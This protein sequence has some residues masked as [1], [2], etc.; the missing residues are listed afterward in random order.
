MN[1]KILD[2]LKTYISKPSIGNK[3]FKVNLHVHARGNDPVEIVENAR[4]SE[5]DIIAITD[6]QTFEYYESIERTAKTEGREL[7]V[8]PGIE[9]TSI[10]GAHL[11]SLFPRNY[12]TTKRA[13]LIGWLGIRDPGNTRAASNKTVTKILNKVNE[14]GGIC[15]IPHPFADNIGL[16]DSARKIETRIEWLESGHVGLIQVNMEKIIYVDK[17]EDGNWINRYLLSSANAEQIKNSNYCL[18]PINRSDAQ[19]PA[20]I[21]DG[22][23]WV[24]MSDPTIIG[25]KQV[26]CEPHT[27][28][29]RTEPPS[30]DHPCI[31]GLGIKGGYF[32]DQHIDF[33]KRMTCIIGQNYAGKSAV[34]DFIRFALSLDTGE[35]ISQKSRKRLLHRID[36]ILQ[37]GGEISLFLLCNDTYYVVKRTYN[38]EYEGGVF[39]RDNITCPTLSS[40]YSLDQAAGCLV[41]VDDFSF[42]IELYEQGRISKLREDIDH[43]L[44]M[45]DEFA[46][47]EDFK[48]KIPILIGQLN[49]YANE[50][51]PLHEEREQLN[52]AISPLETLQEDLEQL[53]EFLQGEDYQKWANSETLAESIVKQIEDL[54][55]VYQYISDDEGE[56][57]EDY[58][59]INTLFYTKESEYDSELLSETSLMED[60]SNALKEAYEKTEDIHI[61]LVNVLEELLAS[62]DEYEKK[63][64]AAKKQYDESLHKKLLD[65]G[66]ASPKE[67]TTKAAEL[68][69]QINTIKSVN[70]P[71]LNVVSQNI[72]EVEEARSKVLVKF[73]DIQQQITKAREKTAQ[74][75]TQDL[76]E[77]IKITIDASGYVEEFRKC[78]NEIC[79][80]ITNQTRKIQNRESQIETIVKTISPITLSHALENKQMV[81]VEDGR[82]VPL[83]EYCQITENTVTIL[84]SLVNDIRLLNKLQT[85]IIQDVPKILVRR[86][87]ETEYG[88]LRTGLSPGEQSAAILT[89]ALMTRSLPLILDQP[90][91]E[92]GYQYVVHHAV[93]RLLRAKA[94]RQLLIISHN[95]NIPVLGDADYVIKLENQPSDGGGRKCSVSSA[96]CFESIDI[97]KALLELEGGKEAFQ[98]RRRRY[99]LPT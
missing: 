68:R 74:V 81:E 33:T 16:L 86:Q 26:T 18:S 60:W 76:E 39:H 51:A 29:S 61:S 66:Y 98:F 27:R 22:C 41:P 80:V 35:S 2:V 99:R 11:L 58:L 47:I 71:R 48:N 77:E 45:I 7:T 38:P 55:Q 12:G 28:I 10:E 20:E 92:L 3:W 63:W 32:D 83:A 94:T 52:I 72:Q 67:I 4:V 65:D 79:D 43:Q 9:I 87:G 91:D 31:L 62:S 59:G 56:I 88:D 57:S 82:S 19:T 17:D 75:L 30:I 50:L 15:V 97:T 70:K 14:E 36:G 89:L 64:K 6:H 34:F 44:D 73:V 96:G 90:E 23:T 53:T 37:E 5:I 95:A 54:R 13:G 85:T 42:P 25:L 8:L 78:L 46:G 84:S 40:A 69:R 93:P 1:D 49:Q 21:S 24:K